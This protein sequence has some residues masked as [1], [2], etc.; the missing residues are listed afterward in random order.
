MLPC[1]MPP[2]YSVYF[3][4]YTDLQMLVVPSSQTV[5]VN[6]TTS[7]FCSA[8]AFYMRWFI[9]GFQLNLRYERQTYADKGITFSGTTEFSPEGLTGVHRFNRT[10]TVVASVAINT[11]NF[12]CVAY[13]H[14]NGSSVSATAQLIVVGKC[15]V[16]LMNRS[17]DGCMVPGA[18]GPLCGGALN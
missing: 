15:W 3:F 16:S 2:L 12:T 4:L 1:H 8:Y 13:V 10:I 11:T 18:Y 17:C 6:T 9:N 5:P 7:F 14:A